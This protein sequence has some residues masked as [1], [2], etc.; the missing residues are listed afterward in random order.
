ME[1][2]PEQDSKAIRKELENIEKK[3]EPLL[4]GTVEKQEKKCEQKKKIGE[5]D[6]NFCISQLDL[7][8]DLENKIFELRMKKSLDSLV[9]CYHIYSEPQEKNQINQNCINLFKK[10][11]NQH[12]YDYERG[13]DNF[14]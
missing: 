11:I 9:D 7:Q 2:F 12:F 4:T 14:M 3:F 10:E 5:K 6:F 13:L 1:G 8:A